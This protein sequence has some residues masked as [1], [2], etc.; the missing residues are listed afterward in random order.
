MKLSNPQL[1]IEERLT[2]SQTEKNAEDRQKRVVDR[3][4]GHHGA[5]AAHGE[6][7]RVDV[8]AIAL[9]EV[10]DE[11]EQNATDRRAEADDRQKKRAVGRVGRHVGQEQAA[12]FCVE[13]RHIVT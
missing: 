11:A 5:Q 7:M 6:A 8:D 3:E 12:L 4:H 2:G 10:T 1:P 13:I 9:M